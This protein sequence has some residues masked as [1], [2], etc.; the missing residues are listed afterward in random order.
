[1]VD[2]AIFLVLAKFATVRRSAFASTPAWIEDAIWIETA[3]QGAGK[4]VK[5][6]ADA[7]LP[8][9]A[10]SVEHLFTPVVER[11]ETLLWAGI[12][13]RVFDKLDINPLASACTRRLLKELCE[14][15]RSPAIYE[16]FAKARK[17]GGTPA[18][19]CRGAT[20]ARRRNM[21]VRSFC[22]RHESRRVPAA[23]RGQAGLVAPDS[24]DHAAMD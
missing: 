6:V 1:M 3:L 4:N 14:P 5:H 18:G 23:V 22:R 8:G 12:D 17:E 15:F 20:T 24:H 9:R 7:F 2:L 11:A 13:A 16:R 10:F 21:A 19:R